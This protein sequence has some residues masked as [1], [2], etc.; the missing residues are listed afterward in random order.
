MS[1]TSTS[2]YSPVNL[3]NAFRDK[4]DG[5]IF[6]AQDSVRNRLNGRTLI[7]YE[8]E[9]PSPVV[10]IKGVTG[11]FNDKIKLNY[12]FDFPDTVLADDAAYVTLSNADTETTLTLPIKEASFTAGKGY[13]F[14]ISLAAKEAGDTITAR[15]YD[16]NDRALEIRGSS[17]GSDY[18]GSGVQYT[19]MQYFDWLSKES[20]DDNE[21]AVGAA[22]RDYCAAAQIYF[23][24][25]ASGLSVSDDVTD[26]DAAALSAFVSEKS[27]TIP[28][29][30]SIKGI[31]AMLESDNT[32]R[33]YFSF[34]DIDPAGFTYTIDGKPVSL[35]QRPDGEYYLALK[36][37]VY[38]NHL[39]DTHTY[40]VSDGTD[41]YM[42]TASVL[43]YARSCVIKKKGTE[44][45]KNLGKA[46]YL[47]NT[48]AV[49][50]FGQ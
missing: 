11:S 37:G 41:T 1:V 40:S 50:A 32:L 27:G 22:A 39:Q 29:G 24:Y 5:T 33:L 31:S 26:L 14:S 7:P 34:E 17:T 30:V 42:I 36:E 46:L 18:T 12:Y 2:Y 49:A 35:S 4:N 21:K 45:E 6:P 8:I 28:T 19:L 44:E 48:A 25:H 10:A 20:E 38:S 3:K 47:Y 9:D 43:T 23:G 16:G 15:V 13:K